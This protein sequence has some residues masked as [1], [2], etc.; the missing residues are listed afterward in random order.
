MAENKSSVNAIVVTVVL[1]VGGLL[2]AWFVSG[3]LW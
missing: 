2:A 3:G 1:V